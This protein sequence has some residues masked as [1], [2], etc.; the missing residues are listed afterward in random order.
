MVGAALHRDSALVEPPDGGEEL[1]AGVAAPAPTCE[2]YCDLVMSN[3][4]GTNAQYGTVKE[5]LA[6][7]ADLPL[8]VPTRDGDDKSAPSIACRQ[9]WADSPARTSP[10]GY[11]LA[12]GPYGGN[13]CGDRCT[14][15]CEVVLAACSPDAG[16]N[17][18]AV[19]APYAISRA[20]RRHAR[21]SP[22]AMRARMAA[23]KACS[24]RTTGD[25][26]NCRLDVLRQAV[27]NPTKCAD[28]RAD[29]QACRD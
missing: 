14:A 7:C 28:L 17:S 18:A 29:S 27:L 23:A 2:K 22:I 3:C 24:G 20:A 1:D 8:D 15:Y 16:T 5:C 11:C 19:E 12:A 26:L 21:A 10:D 4:T 6:F 9:Y 13:A 25:S